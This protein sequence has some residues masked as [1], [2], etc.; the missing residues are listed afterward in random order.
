MS[1]TYIQDNLARFE[2]S[3]KAGY[4]VCNLCKSYVYVSGDRW[5]F[6]CDEIDENHYSSDWFT[7]NAC[8]SGSCL[9]EYLSEQ[10]SFK[11]SGLPKEIRENKRGELKGKLT[12]DIICDSCDKFCDYELP[13]GADNDYYGKHVKNYR[14]RDGYMCQKCRKDQ[15]EKLSMLKQ[16]H[17]WFQDDLP[18]DTED[19]IHVI[20]D[21]CNQLIAYDGEDDI[22]E[23]DENWR[24]ETG[25]C[26]DP[27]KETADD[28]EDN[29]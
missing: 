8:D 17:G 9:Y 21:H 3:T 25:F 20:C 28:D 7:C 18:E 2:G 15:D 12:T 1:A 23:V 11:H 5:S 27:C 22:G 16:L 29:N 6:L 10:H 13:E 14:L 26:C 24:S 19:V 4:V